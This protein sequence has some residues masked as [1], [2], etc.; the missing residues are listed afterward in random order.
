MNICW[1][2]RNLY[3]LRKKY[4]LTQERLGKEVALSASAISNIENS[5]SFPSIDT[6]IK[7]AEYFGVDVVYF[8]NDSND[9]VEDLTIKTKLKTTEEFLRC[10]KNIRHQFTQ[11]RKQYI[12]EESEDHLFYEVKKIQSME[13]KNFLKKD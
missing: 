9:E 3:T 6:L 4:D 5:L 8:L 10:G 13:E 12:L 7:L 1:I 2:G 11:Q